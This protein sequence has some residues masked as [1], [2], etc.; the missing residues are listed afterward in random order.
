NPPIDSIREKS[1]MSLTM[2]LGGRPGLFQ[3]LPRT[4]S[5]VE[6]DSPILFNHEVDALFEV[7]FL[8]DHIVR[9]DATFNAADGPNALELAVAELAGQACAAVE[10]KNAKIVILSDRN[11][12]AE[13]AGIPMLLAVGAVSRR[14]S[15]AGLGLRCDIVA[16]T[17]EARDVHHIAT[18]LGFGATAVNPYLAFDIISQI[19]AS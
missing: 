17:G 7:P 9:L 16:E 8:K 10:D 12:S 2:Y 13:R 3:E 18:L 11:I 15:R 5:Y 4:D 19:A 14:I 1:V 6:L